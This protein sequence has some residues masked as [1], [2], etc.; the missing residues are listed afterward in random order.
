M[1]FY[2]YVKTDQRPEPHDI[3]S[4]LARPEVE[5]MKTE[6]GDLAFYIPKQSL[7]GAMVYPRKDG[8]EVG[9]NAFTPACDAI[10]ARDLAECLG[11]VTQ[12]EVKPEDSDVAVSSDEVALYGGAAWVADRMAEAHMVTRHQKGTDPHNPLTIFGYRRPFN[13]TTAMFKGAK[14]SLGARIDAVMA[15]GVAL[16]EIDRD[17]EI[18]VAKLLR[19]NAPSIW[20]TVVSKLRQWLGLEAKSEGGVP[21]GAAIFSLAEGVR[22]LTPAPVGTQPHYAVLGSQTTG[23]K[24]VPFDVVATA[25]RNIGAREYGVGAFDITLAGSKYDAL[26][27]KGIPI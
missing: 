20:P 7:R 10:L 5:V 27:A 8:Y 24:A 16:Q 4:A 25:A 13:V 2:F 12:A 19:K 17:E 15:D 9:V 1:S 26:Y 18:F 11:R 23:F 3:L 14:G 21:T 22:T 6:D